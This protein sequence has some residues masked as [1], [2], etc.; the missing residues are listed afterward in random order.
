MR[1]RLPRKS[2][3]A[4]ARDFVPRGYG[5]SEEVLRKLPELWQSLYANGQLNAGVVEKADPSQPVTVCGVGISVFV[6]EAFADACLANPQPYLNERLHME[7]LAGRSPVLS[8]AQI[9]SNAGGAGLTLM[10]IHFATPS[11][12]Y[13]NEEVMRIL[14]AAQDLFRMVH[15]GFHVR[16]I[17]KEVAGID[18]CRYM[19]GSGMALHSEY[20]GTEVAKLDPAERP[21]MLA[22]NHADL[23]LGSPMSIMFVRGPVRFEFTPAE[24][25]LLYSALYYERDDELAEV[26]AV[27][28]ETIRK[29]WRSVHE[30]VQDV[31]TAF[32]AADAEPS[33]TGRGRGK[34][35]LLMRYLAHHMEE[36]R[37]YAR[38]HARPKAAG[39]P[40]L[41]VERMSTG[42]PP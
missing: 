24:Q 14:T 30:R 5:Y 9:L 32:Y 1:F 18:L 15:A 4:I 26:L 38:S 12:D 39:S 35:R 10:P 33:G 8:R 19:I 23:P 41:G 25:R 11:F 17:F 20:A 3:F 21:Y 40:K 7:I 22:V 37:P 27:S 29:Q 13:R 42:S 36:L 31:D 2:D 34:R 16:R 6:E 28:L